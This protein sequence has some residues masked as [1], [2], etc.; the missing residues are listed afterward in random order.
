MVNTAVCSLLLLASRVPV[1]AN[2]VA[3]A[4][5]QPRIEAGESDR[6]LH[7]TFLLACY[8]A[9][10]VATAVISLLY[11]GVSKLNVLKARQEE[12]DS[13]PESPFA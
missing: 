12:R 7:L 8:T 11:Y 9:P 10:M 1:I 4:M 2:V 3:D 5:G 6:T 13:E